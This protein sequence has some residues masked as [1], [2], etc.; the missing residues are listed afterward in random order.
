[1]TTAAP[2]HSATPS[3]ARVVAPSEFGLISLIGRTPL[4]DLSGLPGVPT[5]ARILGKAEFQNPAGSVKDRPAWNMVR[6]GLAAG[7]LGPGKTLIDA[8]SGNTGIAYAM[9]GAALRFP[10]RLVLP[11]NAN[12]ERKTILRALGADIVYSS[13]AEGS[14]GAIRLVKKLVEED[15]A[16]GS[17]RYFYPDQYSNDDNWRAHFETTG[18]EILEQTR[19]AVTHFVAGLGTSGTFMGVG[20]RMRRDAPGVRLISV[21]PDGPWHGLEGMKHMPTAIVPPIYDA[22]LADENIEMPTDEAH[23]TTRRIGRLCGLLVGVSAGANVAAAIRVAREAGP[24]AVVVTVLCDG[25]LRYLSE[26]FWHDAPAPSGG[27]H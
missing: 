26:P 21:Q 10:V 18:P 24:S 3:P 9:L 17:P 16:T 14:D 20:R 22:A 7:R 25:G 1:M 11:K 8:T 15:A 12:E 6:N 13:P 27:G 19:G 2:A 5:G 4:I 23:E